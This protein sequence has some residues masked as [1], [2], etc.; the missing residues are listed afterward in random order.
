MLVSIIIPVYQVAPYIT[1]CLQ[2]VTS[3]SYTGGMECILVDDCGVDDSMALARQV[4]SQ[5]RG[6]IQ[7]QI[8]SHDHNRGLSAARN[9]G[10]EGSRGDYLYFLDADDWIDDHCISSLVDLAER[11]PGVEMVQAGAIAHGGEEKPWLNLQKSTLPEFIDT[12]EAVRP[13]MLSRALVPVTAWNRL[14][15]RDFLIQ[16]RLFFKEGIIHEDELW[17]FQLATHLSTLAILKQNVYHYEWHA[18]GLMATE[19]CQKAASLIAIAYQMIEGID[20]CCQPL[21]VAYITDFIHL[22]SFNISQQ[23]QRIV[24]LEALP[25]LYPYYSFFKRQ[26]VRLWYTLAKLPIHH[27]YWLYSLLY[28]WKI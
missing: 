20:D 10:I 2:S 23:S 1:R 6:P 15:K 8:L 12:P 3:Q 17:T 18:S 14:I 19:N 28:H 24:L 27:H 13:L 4:I 22:R 25:R 26:N 5:Y 9:T 7:F 11:H 21:T 16:Y